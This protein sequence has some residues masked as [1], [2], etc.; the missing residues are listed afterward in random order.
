MKTKDFDDDILNEDLSGADQGRQ[1][2]GI[3]K[4]LAAGIGAAVLVCALGLALPTLLE[5]VAPPAESAGRTQP[6]RTAQTPATDAGSLFAVTVYTDGW[7]ETVLAPQVTA[8]LNKYSPAQSDVP[9]LPFIITALS[10]DVNADGLRIDVDAGSL[11]TWG[12]PDYATKQRGRTYVLSSGDTI[13]W[14][15]LDANGT[16]VPVCT[17][18]VTAYGR[19]ETAYAATVAIV[20]VKDS[21]YMAEL[22]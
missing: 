17:M 10:E 14:S 18:T 4:R 19:D 5:A 20:Q 1:S 12:P 22:Q 7:E 9:G 13:Y 2:A 3:K 6:A 16:A 11:I 8:A 21:H 15:P